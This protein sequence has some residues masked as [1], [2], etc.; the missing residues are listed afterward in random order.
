MK[1]TKTDMIHLGADYAF[2]GDSLCWTLYKRRITKKGKEQFDAVGYFSY[3][4]DALKKMAALEI[5]IPNDLIE[6]QDRLN[7]L[8]EMYEI[9][10]SESIF[11]SS[12]G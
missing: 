11:D 6:I 4:S 9:L 2:Q 8:Y 3:L 12:E 1:S 7:R 5:Q 10:C